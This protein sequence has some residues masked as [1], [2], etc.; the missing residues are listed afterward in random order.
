MVNATSIETSGEDVEPDDEPA[1]DTLAWHRP[2]WKW[3]LAAVVA[4]VIQPEIAGLLVGI[5]GLPFGLTTISS[6]LGFTTEAVGL[7]LAWVLITTALVVGGTWLS[8]R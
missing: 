2:A 5:L 1:D 6:A 3:V 8:R 4:L 7:L